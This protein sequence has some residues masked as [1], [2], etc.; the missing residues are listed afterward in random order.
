MCSKSLVLLG[1]HRGILQLITQN[2]ATCQAELAEIVGTVDNVMGGCKGED[3][4]VQREHKV[5]EHEAES[6]K[7]HSARI[8]HV[9]AKSS[10][11]HDDDGEAVGRDGE[12]EIGGEDGQQSGERPHKHGKGNEGPERRRGHVPREE[13]NVSKVAEAEILH[14]SHKVALVHE[15]PVTGP[16]EPDGR[17]EQGLGDKAKGE[18]AR[19]TRVASA[20]GPDEQDHHR[21]AL[22]ETGEGKI[23]ATTRREGWAHDRVRHCRQQRQTIPHRG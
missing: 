13:R 23:I 16:R 2:D 5:G 22:D 12:N 6:A 9:G 18:D 7:S 11:E 21:E 19:L 17:D 10:V 15:R 14:A 20:H 3:E 1:W 4:L 8:C